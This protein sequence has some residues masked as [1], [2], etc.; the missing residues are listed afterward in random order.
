MS[1]SRYFTLPASRARDQL[2]QA[3]VRWSPFIAAAALV[4][5]KTEP[6]LRGNAGLSDWAGP[7]PAAPR[8]V[9][10]VG[11]P[12][13]DMSSAT[14]VGTI[15]SQPNTLSL[16]T[17]TFTGHNH[18]VAKDDYCQVTNGCREGLQVN[19]QFMPQLGENRGLEKLV[20]MVARVAQVPVNEVYTGKGEM[21][22][23][24]D[25]VPIQGNAFLGSVDAL[26]RDLEIRGEHPH[27][28]FKTSKFDKV[29]TNFAEKVDQLSL[30]DPFV[31]LRVWDEESGTNQQYVLDGH[32]RYYSMVRYNAEADLN[33]WPRIDQ[34]PTA[35]I[36]LPKGMTVADVLRM[37]LES[38]EIVERELDKRLA[39]LA[40]AADA[41]PV[42]YAQAFGGGMR[43]KHAVARAAAAQRAHLKDML[44]RF[45]A[46]TRR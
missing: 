23:L 15:D 17:S 8:S 42:L 4:G 44:Q 35:S 28:R 3:G 21:A 26:F 41:T 12:G 29:P 46:A 1:E 31:T 39:N 13:V 36:T 11:V 33:G 9:P 22:S 16:G 34:M 14:A 40:T 20:G 45:H 19:R 24:D 7:P 38:S 30:L 6:F 2:L 27:M 25:L 43:R 18:D 37:G 10:E 32:H 5:T